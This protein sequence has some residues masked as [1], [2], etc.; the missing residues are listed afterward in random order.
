MLNYLR[1][2][3]LKKQHKAVPISLPKKKALPINSPKKYVSTLIKNKFNELNLQYESYGKKNPNKF[4]Y[5]IR[6]TPGAGFFSNLNFVVHNLFICDQLKIDHL[7]KR[8]IKKEYILTILFV[9]FA[10]SWNPKTSLGGD[11]GGIP[12]YRIP[13]KIIEMLL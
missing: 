7:Y 11:V 5:I 9:F 3:I 12:I 10:F 13:Y 8:F 4:F 6:R 1:K 2:I